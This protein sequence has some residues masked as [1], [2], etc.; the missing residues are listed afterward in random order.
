ME[1][2][3]VEDLTFEHALSKEKALKNIS[4]T[5]NQGEF[6]ALCGATGS[7]KSTLLRLI[8]RELAPAGKRDGKIC[9]FGA[10]IEELDP[11]TSAS[12]IGYVMQRPEQQ[13]VT[14]KVWHELAFG[15]EC[16][17]PSSHTSRSK[18]GA[19]ESAIRSNSSFVVLPRIK[20]VYSTAPDI[21]TENSSH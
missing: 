14:D 4:F 21:V 6:V 2:L 12:S 17:T 10:P 19:V 8:K 13:I 3:R 15:P 11:V 7:G 9:L 1:I 18:Y 16:L 20:C 5:L